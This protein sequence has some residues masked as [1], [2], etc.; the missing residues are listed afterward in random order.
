MDEAGDDGND[1][2][3]YAEMSK[4]KNIHNDDKK[5]NGGAGAGA[6]AEDACDGDDY[7]T[8]DDNTSRCC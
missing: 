1:E 3:D 2:D 4:R 7:T 6:I 8:A 5:S